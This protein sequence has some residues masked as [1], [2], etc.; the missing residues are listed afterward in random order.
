MPVQRSGISSDGHK[1]PV[2]SLNV[3]GT[4]IANNIVS[5]S[6][7]GTM[8]LWDAKQL[9]KPV[10]QTTKLTVNRPVRSTRQTNNQTSSTSRSSVTT[11]EIL[12]RNRDEPQSVNVTCCQFPLGDANKY[13]VGSLNGAMYRNATHN[14]SA[15]NITI[16]DEHDGPI[17]GISINNP[18]SEYQALSGLIL[19]SSYDWT[20]KLW[21]PENK[22]SLRTF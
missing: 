22:D 12:S 20:V 18:S 11:S 13:Y 6:N 9:N 15:D 4:Q 7:D 1:Y 2:Y 14:N 3:V 17:S 19:T 10:R 8:G 21:S 5:F 16:F